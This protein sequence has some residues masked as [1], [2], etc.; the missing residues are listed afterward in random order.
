MSVLQLIRGYGI[1]V[2]KFILKVKM[3]FVELVKI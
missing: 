3:M 2:V 1:K